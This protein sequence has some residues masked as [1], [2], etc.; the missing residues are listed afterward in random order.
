[1]AWV[2]P[3]RRPSKCFQY[4]SSSTIAAASALN[5]PCSSQFFLIDLLP[6]D[7]T[8][9]ASCLILLSHWI[10]YNLC[11]N[12]DENPETHLFVHYSFTLLLTFSCF[13]FCSVCSALLPNSSIVN[14]TKENANN[15]LC[16]CVQ[17]QS[18]CGVMLD[19][20][21]VFVSDVRSFRRREMI[22]TKTRKEKKRE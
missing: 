9:S 20:Y 21:F 22:G 13:G 1:M 5:A 16:V 10:S 6:S 17:T 7:Q 18:F 11:G 14:Y 12:I 3:A 2:T 4:N 8:L 15:W 19:F